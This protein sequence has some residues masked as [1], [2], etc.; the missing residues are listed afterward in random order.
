MAGIFLTHAH[1]GHYAG[2]MYLGHEAMGANNVPVYAMPRMKQFLENNGPWDQ[3]SRYNNIQ[4]KPLA[5]KHPVSLTQVS[6][7]PFTVP[8]RD[9]YSETVGYRIQGQ[10][11]TAIFIPDINKWQSWK[12]NIADLVKTVDYAFLDAAFY[13]DGELP[14]RD[15]SKIPHPFVSESMQ[16]FDALPIQQRNKIWFIHMNHTNPLLNKNS[17]EAKLVQSKGYHI[18]QEGLSFDL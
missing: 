12:T 7:T 1:I 5:D 11:K 2:L 6:V 18:A 8:H 3:L 16:I 14:G 15:M 10:H 9:E 13:A 17:P 4:L